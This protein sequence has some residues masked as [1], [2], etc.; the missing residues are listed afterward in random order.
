MWIVPK[1]LRN[2]NA[3]IIP[4]RRRAVKTLAKDPGQNVYHLPNGQGAAVSCDGYCND[5]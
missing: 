1:E 2:G 5:E 4:S 3:V